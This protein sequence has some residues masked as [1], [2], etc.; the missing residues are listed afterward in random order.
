MTI[1]LELFVLF[2]L[3]MEMAELGAAKYAATQAPAGDL[4]KQRAAY[5]EFGEARVKS[6]VNRN[7]VSP[8]R[9]GCAKNSPLKYSRADLIACSNAEKLN[10]IINK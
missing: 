4:I 5:R 2:F 7:L 1:T 6:W 9:V 8:V 10:C 3:C